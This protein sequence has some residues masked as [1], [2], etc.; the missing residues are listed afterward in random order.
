M[1]SCDFGFKF[2]IGLDTGWIGLEKLR[3]IPIEKLQK[4]EEA[5]NIFIVNKVKTD[6]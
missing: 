1:S 5:K 4:K 3:I 2:R 6:F